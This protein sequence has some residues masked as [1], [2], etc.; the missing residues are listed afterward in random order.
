[1]HTSLV[2]IDSIP[3]CKLVC[4]QP[5]TSTFLNLGAKNHVLTSQYKT[6]YA[7]YELVIMYTPVF[8]KY[9]RNTVCIILY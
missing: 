8:I 6:L 4:T 5:D 7:Y 3:N 9:A 1:M 2:C